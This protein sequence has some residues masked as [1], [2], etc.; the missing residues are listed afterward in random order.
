MTPGVAA[1]EVT[2]AHLGA[3]YPFMA[4]SGLG[5]GG[6]Y[7]GRDLLGG[8]FT[9][10][11][12]DLYARGVL[13]NANMVVLGQIGRGK[14]SFVKSF[15]WRQAVFGRRSWVVDPKGEYGSLAAAWG[16]E[17]VVL[18]P[19]GTVRLNPLEVPGG[20]VGDEVERRRVELIDA[21]ASAGMG[22]PLTP[23][24]H[25][26]TSLAVRAASRAVAGTSRMPTVIDVIGTLLSPAHASAAS[27]CTNVGSLADMGRDVAFALKR[28]VDGDLSGMFDGPTTPGIDL[29]GPLVVLD[30]SAVYSSPA[31]GLVMTCATAWL[32]AAIR[33]G[34][35]E[36]PGDAA[37]HPPDGSS[38]GHFPGGAG[39]ADPPG[40]TSAGQPYDAR[41]F[42]V[43]DE[44]WA[45][46]SNLAVARWL[47]SSWKL[48]RSLGVANIAV[49]HRL[50]DLCAAGAAGSEQVSLA[51]GL[52]ADSETRVVYAQPAGEIDR[53]RELLG[54]TATE[55][56]LL[57]RLRR[58]VALW[59]VGPRSFLVEHRFG[60]AER[61][62]IDTDTR[63]RA[64]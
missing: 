50:S 15:L 13:T 61:R 34:G 33:P 57:P 44:A 19:G 56:E 1:H 29:S 60:E 38:A 52:L 28:L 62:I 43:V 14:S 32:S 9:Y 24:E 40:G 4:Q 27:I 51:T 37:A 21:L 45:I 17:P 54:V 22:R 31:L 5:A 8:V 3:A 41:R 25:T 63:M 58:G 64:S 23:S 35:P 20:A 12:F 10:D 47:Q 48:S 16:V 2:T 30:L 6:V 11:P 42:V 36:E 46:L 53:C 18:R 26:A 49:V 55:G 59:K 7:I 39:A